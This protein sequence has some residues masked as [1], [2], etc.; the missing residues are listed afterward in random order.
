MGLPER[1]PDSQPKQA[2][3]ERGLL[4][5]KELFPQKPLPY[6]EV[7]FFGAD[8][9]EGK[10]WVQALTKREMDEINHVQQQPVKDG[11]G[12]VIQEPT[13]VGWDAKV[14]ARALRRPNRQRIFVD[15]WLAGAEKIESQWLPGTVQSVR[16]VVL[17]L[18]GYGREARD[19]IKKGS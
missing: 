5:E 3:Q 9:A 15:N 19:E 10:V 1:V 2:E 18:S 16:A 4:D 8:G 11:R 17:E 14:V 7:D 6:R 12:N 13:Q